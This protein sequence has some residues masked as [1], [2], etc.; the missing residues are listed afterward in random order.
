MQLWYAIKLDFWQFLLMQSFTTYS[1]EMQQFNTLKL[2]NK[3]LKNLSLPEIE[4]QI[5]VTETLKHMKKC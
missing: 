3:L 2:W 1:S 5:L 4:K